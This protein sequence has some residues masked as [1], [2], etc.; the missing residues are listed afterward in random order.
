MLRFVLA[1]PGAISYAGGT[2]LFIRGERDSAMTGF[3]PTLKSRHRFSLNWP[4][5]GAIATGA[6]AI[7]L[8]T[9]AL[10][11]LRD[12]RQFAREYGFDVDQRHAIERI[13]RAHAEAVQFI[14]STFLDDRRELIPREIAEPDDV[15]E[16]LVHA[17]R[18]AS[19][20]ELRRHWSCAVLKVMHG[21]FYIDN[22]LKLRYFP[23]IRRQVFASLDGILIDDGNRHYLTDGELCLPLLQFEKKS[24]K[25]RRSIL[26]K[27]LQKAEY[28]AADI[29]DHLGIRMVFDTRFECLLALQILQRAHL[30][31]A[32]NLESQRTRN[33]LF[34]LAA[35]KQVFAKYRE[36][37]GRAEQYPVEL[38]R[39]V[40]SEMLALA[41]PSA[42]T[43][44]PHSASSY[45]SLQITVRKMIH[46]DAGSLVDDEAMTPAA[47]GEAP[48]ASFFF[49]YEIQLLDRASLEQTLSGPASHGAYKQR[50]IATARRRVLGPRLVE[51]LR[52]PR[53]TP[54]RGAPESS[55]VEAPHAEPGSIDALATAATIAVG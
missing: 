51:W 54:A 10:R 55:P 35:A 14:A 15:L 19:Q 21:V 17:S 1:W 23:A 12:A 24:N 37:L 32:T 16:L 45:Q 25:G 3:T 38:M 43:V 52:L 33:T 4:Y 30:I 42:E 47:A 40:D 29:Y 18:H 48:D 13:R 6:S 27:L 20:H 7:D 11:N 28:V 41:A 2:T 46:L 8:Q 31:S 9:L 36:L 44:N 53:A 49:N 26:L 50:Q 5:L 22:N 39:Q 34:D